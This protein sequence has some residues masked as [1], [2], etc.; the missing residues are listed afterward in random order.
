MTHRTSTPTSE[1]HDLTD[2]RHPRGLLIFGGVLFGAAAIAGLVMIGFGVAQWSDPGDDIHRK[3]RAL[4]WVGFAVAIVCGLL[5]AFFLT[6]RVRVSI[7]DETIQHHWSF[8]GVTRFRSLPNDGNGHLTVASRTTSTGEHGTV[9]YWPVHYVHGDENIEVHRFDSARDGRQWA[10]RLAT[11]LDVALIDAAHGEAIVR[12]RGTLDTAV[13]DL[14]FSAAAAVDDPA[15]PPVPPSERIDVYPF[16][17]G[18]RV[19]IAPAGMGF[20][21]VFGILLV[22]GMAYTG[23]LVYGNHP[24]GET[25]IPLAWTIFGFI[26]VG[27]FGA[28]G[29]RVIW[30][31]FWYHESWASTPSGVSKLG[32]GASSSAHMDGTEIEMVTL[33]EARDAVLLVSDERELSVGHDLSTEDATSLKH[34][35]VRG[36]HGQGLPEPS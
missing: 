25:G 16:E 23:T 34:L 35:V 10:E 14:D 12:E 5:A 31:A 4:F 18:V 17:D 26:V 1:D 22:L 8:L 9:T 19:D 6:T 27:A 30:L 20:S 3:A 15:Q 11:K 7:D 29:L 24:T 28:V 21:A 33:N 2:I 13:Q 36:L 32:R